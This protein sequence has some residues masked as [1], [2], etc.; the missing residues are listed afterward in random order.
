MDSNFSELSKSL[1]KRLSKETKKDEGIYFTPKVIIKK[2]VDF[3]LNTNFNI[4]SILEPSCGSGQFID[5][6]NEVYSGFILGIE[7]NETIYNS[8]K[9]KSDIVNA[10]FLEV[11][12]ERNFDL[13]IGNPPYFE[14]K[15]LD[16]ETKKDFADVIAGRPNIFSLFLKL[17][18]LY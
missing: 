13:V 5:Y 15:A 10:D 4:E 8:L 11:K 6:L 9:N 1:T 7:K 2:M 12:F 16:Q 3:V 17:F 18:S 14:M